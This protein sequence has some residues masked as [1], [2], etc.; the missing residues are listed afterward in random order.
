MNRNAGILVLIVITICLPGYA[1][2]GKLTALT[3][4]TLIDGNGGDPTPDTTILIEGER[5]VEI[6]PAASVTIP[7]SAT[8]IEH[9]NPMQ[10]EV[11]DL[12]AD[13][14]VHLVPTLAIYRMDYQLKIPSLMNL[15]ETRGW[16]MSVHEDLFQKAHQRSGSG[17]ER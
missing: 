10:D 7:A 3:G 17:G 16:S 2:E 12:I 8:R 15:V 1:G 13:G 5:I 6:G 14:G 4:G 11:L 9:V